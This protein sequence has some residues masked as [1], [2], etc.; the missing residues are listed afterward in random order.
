MSDTGI[1][2]PIEQ[3]GRIFDLFHVLGSLSTHSSSKVAFQGGGLGLGLPSAKGIIE[4]HQGT[5]RIE[6]S[7]QDLEALPGSTCYI[8]LPRFDTE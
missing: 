8:L 5:I 6:S 1:G 2:I 4:A 3:Q 7:G